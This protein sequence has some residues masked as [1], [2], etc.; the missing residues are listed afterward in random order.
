VWEFHEHL[1]VFF[2][3]VGMA[4]SSPD[5]TIKPVANETLSAGSKVLTSFAEIE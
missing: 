1:R 4:V 3:M 2:S 5:N